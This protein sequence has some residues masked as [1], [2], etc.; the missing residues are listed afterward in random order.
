MAPM[1]LSDPLNWNFVDLN[2][3]FASVEQQENPALR[4]KPV[5]VVPSLVNTTCCIA[6][7]YEAKAFGIKTG[8]LVGE[9]NIRCP[10]ITL[11][12]GH[13]KLYRHYHNRLVEAVESCVPVD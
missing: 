6:V 3:Y 13:H 8:T 12:E 2:A 4:G 11:I 5:A 9:A 10:E 7:S 1:T